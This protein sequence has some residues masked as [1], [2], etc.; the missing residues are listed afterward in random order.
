EERWAKRVLG[1]RSAPAAEHSRYSNGAVEQNFQM[2]LRAIYKMTLEWRRVVQGWAEDD[3]RLVNDE[4][5][6]W[7][8]GLDEFAAMVWR[9]TRWV[10]KAGRKD[11]LRREDVL[12]ENEDSNHIWSRLVM[13]FSESH[14]RLLKLMKDFKANPAAAAV[15]G[16]N[17]QI[18]LVLRTMGAR[19]R[20]AAF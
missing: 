20:P 11:G 13:Y 18:E 1:M 4:S 9:Y 3:P 17:D 14:L 15:F 12:E 10:I 7:L 5:D 2:Q 19:A 16:L 6:E 8:N